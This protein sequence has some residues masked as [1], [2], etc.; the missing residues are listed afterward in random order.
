MFCW[1]T[2][3]YFINVGSALIWADC[4]KRLQTT[5]FHGQRELFYNFFVIYHMETSWVEVKSDLLEGG[6]RGVIAE[7]QDV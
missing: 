4:D 3:V 7:E 1:I 5:T 2:I 6:M